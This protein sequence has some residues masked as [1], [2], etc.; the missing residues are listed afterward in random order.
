[1]TSD[2]L[3]YFVSAIIVGWCTRCWVQLYNLRR[4]SGGNIYELLRLLDTVR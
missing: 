4:A 1:M 3:G 2:M